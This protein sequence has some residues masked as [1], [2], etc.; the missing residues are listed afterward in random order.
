MKIGR[1]E[2][3]M[4]NNDKSYQILNNY[5]KKYNIKDNNILNDILENIFKS[6]FLIVNKDAVIHSSKKYNKYI[7]KEPSDFIK[8]LLNQK[9]I[10][11]GRL[12]LEIINGSVIHGPFMYKSIKQGNKVGLFIFKYNSDYFNSDN[13]EVLEKLYNYIRIS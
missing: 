12:Y 6:D 11:G 1:K 10:D 8:K 5:K 4:D 13:L 9:Y 2:K 7:G 3:T